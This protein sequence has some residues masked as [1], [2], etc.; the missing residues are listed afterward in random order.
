MSQNSA[1]QL[2]RALGE[3]CATLSI[4]AEPNLCDRSVL[5]DAVDVCL[6]GDPPFHA[7]HIGVGFIRD[8][9]QAVR[10]IGND[11]HG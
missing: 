11:V 5:T 9:R 4:A 7:E 8:A 10:E 2:R 6:M 3:T 1:R